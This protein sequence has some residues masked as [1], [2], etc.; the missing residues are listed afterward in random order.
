MSDMLVLGW[1]WVRYCLLLNT[2][3]QPEFYECAVSCS[4]RKGSVRSMASY[5][6]PER[7]QILTSVGAVMVPPRTGY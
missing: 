3:H 7:E 6:F 4:V 1:A 5:V 2:G